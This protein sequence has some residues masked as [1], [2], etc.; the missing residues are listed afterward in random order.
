MNIIEDKITNFHQFF[1]I[2]F[3]YIK[4]WFKKLFS[5]FICF[6]INYDFHVIT[7]WMH[8]TLLMILF[9]E[10]IKLFVMLNE[11]SLRKIFW[12]YLWYLLLIYFLTDSVFLS[13]LLILF[14]IIVTL[15]CYWR[16]YSWKFVKIF[17]LLCILQLYILFLV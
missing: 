5:N 16:S 9:L 3:I 4:E 14:K 15:N 11:F 1:Q 8:Y 7:F 10:E 17:F 13:P 6:V 2:I 12:N